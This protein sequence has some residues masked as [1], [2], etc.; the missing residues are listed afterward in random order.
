MVAPGGY[1]DGDRNASNGFSFG[2]QTD[3]VRGWTEYDQRCGHV[4]STGSVDLADTQNGSGASGVS[5]VQALAN[6]LGSV[7]KMLQDLQI[8]LDSRG[9]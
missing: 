4:A 3:W 1:C 5:K 2:S 7:E 9:Q 8:Y 6:A